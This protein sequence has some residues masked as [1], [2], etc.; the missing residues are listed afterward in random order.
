MTTDY[1][2]P[3]ANAVSRLR[4]STPG[5]RREVYDH[6]RQLLLEE[7][8]NSRPPMRVSELVQEQRDL[9]AAIQAVEAQ[10]A[11]RERARTP[12]P[13]AKAPPASERLSERDKLVRDRRERERIAAERAEQFREEERRAAAG[14][15]R[16]AKGTEPEF[17]EEDAPQQRGGRRPRAARPARPAARAPKPKQAGR[18]TG[19]VIALLV[20]LLVLLGLGS[21]G[22]YVYA[23]GLWRA[24]L[25]ELFPAKQTAPAQKK[26]EA[27]AP[28][29]AK[30]PEQKTAEVRNLGVQ[31]AQLMEKGDAPGAIVLLDQAAALDGANPATFTLRGHARLQTG[32]ADRAIADFT[33]AVRLGSKDFYTYVGRGVA[34][35][36]KRD[37]PRAL[38][39][40]N[41]AIKIRADH[42]GAWNNRCFVQAIIGNLPAALGDCNEAL[43]LAPDEPNALDSRALVYLKLQQYDLAIADYDKVLKQAPTTPSALYGRGFARVKKGD[44]RGQADLATAT[45]AVPQIAEEF[46]RYGIK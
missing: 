13:P 24:A 9:E 20:F 23:T 26:A 32:D 1:F 29:P 39:D 6:A 17:E 21:A 38:D 3:I 36:R 27:P 4:P 41:A 30:T 37:Y 44:S 8:R 45:A 28:A 31:A 42:S 15:D 2:T 14:A 12:D 19:T 25:S 7:A 18:R 10:A 5:S 33:E 16:R 40:Y 34:Y 43:R 11:F 22:Y 46:G 35:R